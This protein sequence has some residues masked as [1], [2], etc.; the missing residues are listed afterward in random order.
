MFKKIAEDPE[1]L[2]VSNASIEV[3][4][5]SNDEYCFSGDPDLCKILMEYIF[6]KFDQILR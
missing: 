1:T 3:K 2:F 4:H 6:T 5:Q